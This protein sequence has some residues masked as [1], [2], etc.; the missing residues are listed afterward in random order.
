MST[1]R[2]V[3][4]G[5]ALRDVGYYAPDDP[6]PGS[7][8]ARYYESHW[9]PGQSWLLGPSTSVWW[10]CMA[11]SVWLEEAGIKLA[12]FPSW[13]TENTLAKTHSRVSLEDARPGD[14]IFFDWDPDGSTDHVGIIVD[15]DASRNYL[16][17]VEGNYNNAVALVDRSNVWGMF[18]PAVIPLDT[19][20]TSDRIAEDGYLGYFTIDALQRVLRHMG[21]YRGEV[22]GIIDGLPYADFPS[23]TVEALQKWINLELTRLT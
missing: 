19:E 6:E 9:A 18:T 17:C 12:G 11:V 21:L 4:I 3:L 15:I 8:F 14:I 5:T 10:C 22:D 16:Q 1:D 23:L 20:P 13:N 7:K 2:D